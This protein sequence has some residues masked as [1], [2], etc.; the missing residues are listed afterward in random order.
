MQKVSLH[1]LFG[2][3]R[4]AVGR[5]QHINHQIPESANSI[6]AQTG[7]KRC[8]RVHFNSRAEGHTRMDRPSFVRIDFHI[9]DWE[10]FFSLLTPFHK[11]HTQASTV[12]CNVPTNF[13]L[14][15]PTRSS[16]STAPSSFRRMFLSCRS[17]LIM[18]F[19]TAEQLCMLLD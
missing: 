16:N 6:H 17:N 5:I 11:K 7:I 4:L 13:T 3:L 8:K 14:N 19:D 1:I 15:S 12:H 10:I 9:R 18:N 2:F